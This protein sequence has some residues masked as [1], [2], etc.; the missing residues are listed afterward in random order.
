L[1][2]PDLHQNLA[3]A[4]EGRIRLPPVST[5]ATNNRLRWVTKSTIRPPTTIFPS[6]AS[7]MTKGRR[8]VRAGLQ[9]IERSSG[10]RTIDRACRPDQARDDAGTGR[11]GVAGEV[12]AVGLDHDL[13]MSRRA[14]SLP[15][16]FTNLPPSNDGSSSPAASAFGGAVH[17]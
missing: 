9:P 12:P 13:V 8:L 10:H 16:G 17:V 6:D 7:A 2:P 11:G 1:D 5:R 3:L 4:I 15:R 14:R